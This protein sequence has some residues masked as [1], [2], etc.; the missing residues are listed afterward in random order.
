MYALKSTNR[1]VAAMEILTATTVSL[2]W[3][4]VGP[5]QKSR[6][7]GGEDAKIVS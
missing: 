7:N 5:T 6:F 3:R 2:E 4:N 1:F